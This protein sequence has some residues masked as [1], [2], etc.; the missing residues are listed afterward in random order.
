MYYYFDKGVCVLA[1]EEL[2]QYNADM[3]E[4]NINLPPSMVTLVDG[5]VKEKIVDIDSLKKYKLEELNKIARFKYTQG[6]KSNA[7]QGIEMYYDSDTDKQREISQVA[8]MTAD[9]FSMF[10]PN[11]FLIRCKL[12]PNADKQILYLTLDEMHKLCADMFAW[13]Q[14]VKCYVWSYQ[15]KINECKNKEELDAIVLEFPN[16]VVNEVT[17]MYGTGGDK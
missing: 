9:L 7:H 14:T 4:S 2:V 5:E 3:Y 16:K 1:S 17:T 8:G 6:F 10:F 11:G 12:E 15:T 13:C